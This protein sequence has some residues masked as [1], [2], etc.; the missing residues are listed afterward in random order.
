MLVTLELE[1]VVFKGGGTASGSFTVDMDNKTFSN[2]S[3]K[4]TAGMGDIEGN[5]FPGVAYSGDVLDSEFE[6]E[7]KLRRV[8]FVTTGGNN[9]T[10]EFTFQ[11]YF[12]RPN[13]LTNEGDVEVTN[14]VS[15]GD[16]SKLLDSETV[17]ACNNIKDARAIRPNTNSVVRVRVVEVG[18]SVPAA[19]EK[20]RIG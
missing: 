6:D 20:L 7:V 16:F 9:L 10:G 15:V 14:A 12:Q 2:V 4:T 1:C 13:P 11:L 5:L 17:E 18:Q 3:I 8:R 19:P